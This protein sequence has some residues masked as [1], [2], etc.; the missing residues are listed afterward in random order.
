VAQK[1]GAAYSQFRPERYYL[2]QTFGLGGEHDDV[3]DAANQLPGKRDVDRVRS[4]SA[5]SRAGDFFDANS[6][7]K[8][9][10][11]D[12]MNWAMWSSAAY[13]FSA[14]LTY[15]R[16]SRR[17]QWQGAALCAPHWSKCQPPKRSGAVELEER[18]ARRWR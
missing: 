5:A 10:R 7:A 2:K 13:D 17:T 1:A 6:Y 14:D 16:P 15:A 12:F 3:A 18:Y 11:A 8:D 4:S 9:P